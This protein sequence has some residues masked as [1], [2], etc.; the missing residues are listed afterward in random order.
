VLDVEADSQPTGRWLCIIC[1]R[2]TVTRP[3][4]GRKYT[5]KSTM[6]LREQ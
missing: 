2:G 1:S 3:Q 5:R 6:K 4:D